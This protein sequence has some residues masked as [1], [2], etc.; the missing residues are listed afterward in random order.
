VPSKSGHEPLVS[1]TGDS[2]RPL[3]NYLTTWVDKT[4]ISEKKKDKEKKVKVFKKSKS[5]SIKMGAASVGGSG[6]GA[7]TLYSFDDDLSEMAAPA[8]KKAGYKGEE[9]PRTGAEAG[10]DLFEEPIREGEKKVVYCGLVKTD[11]NGL[12]EVNVKLPPQTGRCNARFVA[13]RGFDYLEKIETI[14]VHKGDSVE[15]DLQPLLIPGAKVKASAHVTNGGKEKAVLKIWGAGIG[16]ALSMWI[17][18]GTHVV[19]FDVTGGKY[20][21]MNLKLA[22]KAGKTLDLRKIKIRNVASMPVTYSDVVLSD[23]SEITV[24]KGRKVAVYKN[25]AMLLGGMVSNVTTT[26]YSWFGHSEA[27]SASCAVRAM[28]LR[29]MEEKIIDD[30]GHRDTL[31]ADLNKTVKDLDEAF[32]DRDKKLFRPYPGMEASET[33]SLWA[34]RNLS[35]ALAA[36][37]GN[38]TLKKE[39]ADAIARARAMV[40]DTNGELKKRGAKFKED[41][42]HDP[43]SGQDVIPI[44]VNGKVVYKLVTDGAVVKWYVDNMMPLLDIPTAK[45]LGDLN[46]RIIK[47]YDLHRF[48]KAFERTGHLYYLL[49]NAKALYLKKDKNFM[50]L[51]N[52]IARGLIFTKDP[53]LIQGPALLGGVYSGPSTFVKFLDLLVAMAGDKKIKGGAKVEITAGG[54]SRKEK[55]SGDPLIVQDKKNAV[56]IKADAYVTLRIDDTRSIKLYDYLE[57]E[58]FFKVKV[59]HAKLKVG[60]ENVFSV[61]LDKDRDASE[62]YAIIAAPSVLSIRQTDDLLSD[63]KGQLIYGQKSGGGERIQLLTA[64]FRGSGT[65]TLKL[66]GA[67]PGAS[68]GYVLVRH[69][70]NP[71]I[72][73]AVEIETITVK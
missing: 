45:K 27:L 18:P 21:T 29:A 30:E 73:A 70:S 39:F 8:P 1:A 41:A 54:E 61:V 68:K 38:K 72:I 60:A 7:G 43:D 5:P 22:D 15:A 50:P 4:G 23:G 12:A 42:F 25:P 17:K 71:E 52:Q 47:A 26:L 32:F 66:E 36:L 33:W 49:L 20:G 44:E 16:K 14:D 63:Y 37:E 11:G 59:K 64:P 51:F 13:V 65:M 35:D 10:D 19:P 55:I 57:N 24:P 67:I 2:I 6:K 40:K 48:L 34:S 53:G 3:S 62:Y 9:A 69:I 46:A 56:K 28:L 58:A 31:A